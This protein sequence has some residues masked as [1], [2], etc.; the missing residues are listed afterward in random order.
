LEAIPVVVLARIKVAPGTILAYRGHQVAPWLV[1]IEVI[2]LVEQ[3]GHRPAAGH[4]ARLANHVRNPVRGTHAV[5]VQ[6]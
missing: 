1:E 6:Q 4:L 2:V 5:A 3:D